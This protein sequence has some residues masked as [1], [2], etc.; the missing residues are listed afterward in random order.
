MLEKTLK[1]S[2][3][4][5]CH[6]ETELLEANLVEVMAVRL[7]ARARSTQLDQ[8]LK[9]VR[10]SEQ[11]TKITSF[12]AFNNQQVKQGEDIDNKPKVSLLLM[13]IVRHYLQCWWKAQV[14]E[15]SL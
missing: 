6:T 8:D 14:E 2:E 12:P 15:C 13:R 7:T 5:R 3:A 10:G 4:E 11:A 9:P 1:V